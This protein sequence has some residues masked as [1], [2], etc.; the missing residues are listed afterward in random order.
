MNTTID[1]NNL[2][3]IRKIGLQALKDA[4][5]P[6]GMVRFIQQYENGYGDYTKEKYQQPN[7]TVEEIDTILRNK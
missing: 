2:I 5:G 6:V 1:V 7:L 3:E 4:L